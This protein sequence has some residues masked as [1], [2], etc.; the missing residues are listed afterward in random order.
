[1]L[2][3]LFYL[4]LLI[5]FSGLRAQQFSTHYKIKKIVAS[6][7]GVQLDSISLNSSF[8]KLENAK[9]KRIDSSYYTID[10]QK[11]LLTFNPSF[12][13]Y[14]DTLTVRFL[15]FPDFLTKEYSIY[16]R[17]RVVSNDAAL[18]D[19]Y[20]VNFASTK[21]Y[22]PFDGLTTSGSLTRGITIGNNQNSVLN[23][24]LDLQISG[25]ISDKVTLRASIQDSN[26]PLQEGGYSQRL[27]EF[28]QLFIEL[29]SDKW[30]VRAG[31]LF[32]ENRTS[33]F[34]NFNK[35]VQ[36]LSSRFEFGNVNSKTTVFASAALVRGKYAK[37]TFIGQE[38]NQGPYKLRG[39]NGELYVLV[40]SGS[41]RVYVNG[42]L[43]TRGENNDYIIDYNAGEITFTSIFPITSEMRISIE[44]QYSDR[45]YT[46]FITYA[47]ASKENEK[48]S[49]GGYLYSENDMKNQPL[50][51]NLSSEQ[52]QTLVNAGDDLNLMSSSSAYLDGYS[53]NKILYKKTLFNGI[54]IFVYSNA[55][56]DE[57]YN[58]K[59]SFVGNN[60]GNYVLSSA[61]AIGKIYRY[62]APLNGISQ[63]NYEPI[64]RLIAPTELQIATVLGK[65]NPSEKT[66]LDFEIGVS[67]NDNNLF[68]SIDDSDNH[69]IAGKINLKQRLFSKK[70]KV[71]Y[72][73]NY[74]LIQ[75]QFKT[76]ERLFSIEFDRDWNLNNPVGTQS[77]LVSGLR[78][79]LP[80]KGVI[81][82]Q[83]ENLGFKDSFS[84]TRQVVNGN[85]NL[86][87]WSIQN[88]G[89]YLKSSGDYSA[90]VFIR[91]QTQVKY[92]IKKNWAGA[93]LRLED[94]QEKLKA[95]NLFSSLSQKF[96]EFGGFIGRGDSTKV[97]IELGY[98][99]RSNDS[100][101]SGLIKRVNNSQSYYLKS[102]LIKTDTRDLSLF[103]NYRN[104]KFTDLTRTAE[105]S[106]NSRVLYNDRF[107]NQ[108]IQL[109]TVYETNSGS[110]A[111]QEFTYLEVEPGRG[112]YSWSD[113]NNNGVQDLEEFQ[114]APF[115]DQAKYIRLFL[116]NQVYLK[117]HQNKFSQ[118]VTINMSQWQN[119]KGFKRFLSY[120]YNQSAFLGERKIKRLG[121]DFDFNPFSANDNNLL[122]LNS[123]FRNS[124]FFN[125][126]KQK[127]SMTYTFLM[128]RIKNLLSVGSQENSN[129]SH[130]LQYT[131]LYEKNWLL[132]FGSK[133]INSE[134]SSENYSA[135]NYHLN[136]YQVAPKIS[137]L[138]SKNASW[139]LFYEYQKKANKM[140][141]LETLAQSRFGTSFNYSSE[142]KLT[143]N[144][145]FS[146]YENSYVGNSLT[147]VAYEMLEG[148]Q[149]GSNSTW[150]LLI[151]K[152]LTN[153]LD[154][155]L[156]YQGRKSENSNAIHTGNIQL[157]AYF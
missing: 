82:Y 63:G 80:E 115:I 92:H 67:N 148:L 93:T 134:M 152:N 76:I 75:R 4:L 106:L 105:P 135:R 13:N 10:F 61:A 99:N 117:T 53:E 121:D 113:Y 44:Y 127:H 107:F 111:Q 2:R 42:I 131:H 5:S 51:Q 102:K 96:T 47:G 41:E 118:S 78:F 12:S 26:I 147:P 1:M 14:N 141:L 21:K 114:V 145:E 142:K 84:G 156:N 38:G 138:F 98:L 81:T 90:S 19:L 40:I 43:L 140:G 6:K 25:K 77:Y 137:Y 55:S 48:W 116:P 144:G 7:N 8:F 27:D 37:S 64:V 16:D 50:Q 154:I 46:R 91:N 88:K 143:M 62:I 18:G 104:L 150:R 110:I 31:D 129:Q 15:K 112:I 101:Q 97:F 151:Q 68:S 119:E 56:T 123:N 155:N 45:N 132:N 24:A 57:L 49:I 74:Q 54:S 22:I 65:F 33:K 139:D 69:G 59:F 72:F 23:S 128:G 133:T 35:K 120:F 87:K 60:L 71:D 28:D 95:T 94:N 109:A 36:G 66:S 153:Y 103:V 100:I 89:S 30:S 85:L 86:K 3:K 130:Q 32:L 17:S 124:L 108:L 126:G 11:S 149:P 125:R 52:V 146:M 136:G 157:R 9:G 70:W 34:L 122:G 79:N 20:L 73:A 83:F 29:S 58:V 39:A